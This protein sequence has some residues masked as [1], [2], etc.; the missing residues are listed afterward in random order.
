MDRN[1]FKAKWNQIKSHLKQKWNRISDDEIN[2]VQGDMDKFISKLQQH[3]GMDRTRAE[4]ELNAYVTTVAGSASST[5]PNNKPGT[6][7]Q[8]PKNPNA[9][10]GKQGGHPGKQNPP[11][12]EHGNPHRKAG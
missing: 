3:Y 2:Q 6:S 5:A 9:Q 4:S 10:P 7:S 8:T 11:S 12:K 1:T